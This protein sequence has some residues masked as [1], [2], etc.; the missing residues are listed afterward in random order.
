MGCCFY[1][2]RLQKILSC[3]ERKFVTCCS[4]LNCSLGTTKSNA[5]SAEAFEKIDRESVQ[6]IERI[7][8]HYLICIDYRYVVNAAKEARNVE[9]ETQRI[10]YLS[11]L[12]FSMLCI[13]PL[14]GPYSQIVNGRKL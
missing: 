10:I 4:F 2:V 14:T 3:G 8:F 5:G 6:V 7:L 1:H 13:H 11:V 12:L 9:L